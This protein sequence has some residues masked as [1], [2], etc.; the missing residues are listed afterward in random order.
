MESDQRPGEREPETPSPEP[1]EPP[2]IEDIDTANAPATVAAGIPH[3][4]P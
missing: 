1:Y 4:G 2:R 3:S